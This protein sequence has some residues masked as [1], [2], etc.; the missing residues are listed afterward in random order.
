MISWLQHLYLWIQITLMN[1]FLVVIQLRFRDQHDRENIFK[2]IAHRLSEKGFQTKVM[3]KDLINYMLP[4]G[5][6]LIQTSESKQV[7]YKEVYNC[8]YAVLGLIFYEHVKT[9]FSFIMANIGHSLQWFS[10]EKD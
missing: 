3:G 5:T 7:I 10:L 9:K 8:C 1:Q 4:K 6:L 2:E